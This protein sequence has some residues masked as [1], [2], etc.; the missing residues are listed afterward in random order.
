M[1]SSCVVIFVYPFSFQATGRVL[2]LSIHTTWLWGQTS[3]MRIITSFGVDLHMLSVMIWPSASLTRGG[4]DHTKRGSPISG[5]AQVET[6]SSG[7]TSRRP[8]DIVHLQEIHSNAFTLDQGPLPS[9]R[10]PGPSQHHFRLLPHSPCPSWSS[11]SGGLPLAH[12]PTVGYGP[13]QTDLV[14]P[15][16]SSSPIHWPDGALRR[17]TGHWRDS[18]ECFQLR[19]W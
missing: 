11:I 3:V 10:R 13:G 14:E 8:K 7:H 17:L 15:P 4:T 6:S 2:H 16:S 18:I 5:A 9:T 12:V 19:P 1:M